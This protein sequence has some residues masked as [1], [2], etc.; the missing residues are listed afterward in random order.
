M[1]S[2][3]KL[4]WVLLLIGSGVMFGQREM[5]ADVGFFRIV[6]VVAAGEGNL[7]MTME[8]KEYWPQ[9]FKLGQR[10][11]GIGMKAGKKEFVLRK[12]GC[13]GV[14]RSLD[15]VAGET[16]TFVCYADPVRDEEGKI[17]DWELKIARLRQHTPEKGLF[18][19]LVSFCEDKELAIEI[20]ETASGEVVKVVVPKMKTTRAALQGGLVNAEIKHRGEVVTHVMAEKAGNYVVMLYND[21]DGAKKGMVFYDPKFVLAN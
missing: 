10:T 15:V 2:H 8:G 19:T 21:A 13:T 6:N 12:D 14:K 3:L 7:K 5:P 9:G 4:V 1:R 20:N 18:V 11:G 17:I 16:Q